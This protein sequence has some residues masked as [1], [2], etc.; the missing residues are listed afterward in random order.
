MCNAM[1]VCNVAVNHNT[2]R[3]S[4]QQLLYFAMQHHK[5][6]CIG[7]VGKLRILATHF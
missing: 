3:P 7:F 6:D 5:A 4:Y 2:I 1:R